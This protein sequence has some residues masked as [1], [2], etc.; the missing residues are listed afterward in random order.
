[1]IRENCGKCNFRNLLLWKIVEGAPYLFTTVDKIPKVTPRL[2]PVWKKRPVVTRGVGI[3]A[4]YTCQPGDARR[5]D[6]RWCMLHHH[7]Q[8]A[9]SMMQA[10][11][12]VPGIHHPCTTLAPSLGR[13]RLAQA[14]DLRVVAYHAHA[15]GAAHA[16]LGFTF[17]G[18]NSLSRNRI[19]SLRRIGPW[20]LICSFIHSSNLYL[21]SLT[22]YILPHLNV[23]NVRI[24]NLHNPYTMLRFYQLVLL[25]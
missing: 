6:N 14:P 17:L 9:S 21:L 10:R 2:T 5:L 3:P 19:P 25:K 15:S 11:R 8:R 22:D 12:R 24:H 23:R 4:G 7:H 20:P 16:Q 13:E 18:P 1:M